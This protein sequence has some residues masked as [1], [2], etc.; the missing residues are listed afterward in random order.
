MTRTRPPWQTGCPLSRTQWRTLQ[1]RR[2]TSIAV[3]P[4][5]IRPLCF[6]PTR[7]VDDDMRQRNV[8]PLQFFLAL[9]EPCIIIALN[10]NRLPPP[11]GNFKCGTRDHVCSRRLRL[12]HRTESKL[13]NLRDWK[14]LPDVRDCMG[15][16]VNSDSEYWRTLIY[17]SSAQTPQEPITLKQTIPGCPENAYPG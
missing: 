17:V 6:P 7:L 5:R 10:Y 16:V 14:L 15:W 9:C 12:D 1:L 3:S 2:L 13:I 11:D 8:K 4:R